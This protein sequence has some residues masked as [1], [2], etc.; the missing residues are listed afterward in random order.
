[1]TPVMATLRILP[2]FRRQPKADKTHP[3]KAAIKETV[4]LMGRNTHAKMAMMSPMSAKE[5]NA[6]RLSTLTL[7]LAEESFLTLVMLSVAL[8]VLSIL[9][10]A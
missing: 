8:F 4:P 10:I 1:M 3:I 2:G 7:A 9:K 5:R 6:T